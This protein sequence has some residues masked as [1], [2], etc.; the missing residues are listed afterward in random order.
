MC[1]NKENIVSISNPAEWFIFLCLQ[2]L[3]FHLIHENPSIRWST[4]CTY[5]HSR[6]LLFDLIIKLKKIIF[7][8]NPLI[9]TKSYVGIFFCSRLSSASFRA[10]SLTLPG[11]LGYKPTSSTMTN[12]ALS[13]I[14]PNL[15][16]L[17]MKSLE[18][19][20]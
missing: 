7:Q 19:L 20:V 4:L 12:I 5:G 2:K 14:F 18:S 15:R 8:N 10:L 1:S 17:L 6:D 9:R 16:D 3:C 13:R 11:M